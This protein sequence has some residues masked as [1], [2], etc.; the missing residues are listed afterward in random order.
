MLPRVL[1]VTYYFPPAGGP[2]VQRVLK[3]V[4]YLRDAGFEPVVLTVKDGAFPSQDAAL[5]DDVPEGV[6]IIRTRAP[7]PFALYARLKG[8]A[9]GSVPTGSVEA[10]TRLARLALWVR[11][12]LFLP[13]ARVGWVPFAIAAG[14]KRLGE[15]AQL[16]DLFAAVITSGPPHSAHLVGRQLQK[17]G[18]P[19]VA[20]FRDP[21]TGINFYHNLPM[22]RPAR[23]LDRRLERRVLQSADAVTTVSPT[24]AR[25]LERQGGLAPG[26]VEVVHNGVDEADLEA[27]DGVSV[28]TDAF[29][30][31]HVGSLYATRDPV[32][33]WQAIR[34]LRDRGEIPRLVI[35]LVGRTDDA[36]RQ[37][38][39][40]TG[41]PV[42]ARPYVTHAEAV[43]E[44]ARAALLLLSIEPFPASDGMITGKLYEYLAS[45]RPV[46]GVGPVGGDAAALLAETGGG[47][48]A[49]R[50]DVAG[51]EEILLEHYAVWEAGTPRAGAPWDAVAPYTRRA[52][53]QR[54]AHVIRQLGR[55]G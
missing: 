45:G 30:L 6:E 26:S 19:W 36:V 42:E 37:S 15:A 7:D 33:V 49:D 55:R 32:A 35:R 3:T 54:L 51:I 28:R 31:A 25:L 2:G 20:D 11:A 10:E 48:L 14:R 38:A 39:E 13:D 47:A 16:A 12:N 43:R 53:T 24:W 27:A 4:R 17:T 9:P 41:A 18:V 40:A 44:Q 46:L 21:W 50:G 22:S 23:A 1:V 8:S 34:R 29:V 52:Q 5:A